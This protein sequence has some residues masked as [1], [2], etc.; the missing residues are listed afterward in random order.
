VLGA[1]AEPCIALQEDTGSVLGAEAEPCIALQED[2]GSVL[3]AEVEPCI[4]LQED[5]GSVLDNAQ[6]HIRHK[7]S[8]RTDKTLK[9]IREVGQGIQRIKMS[10]LEFITQFLKCVEKLRILL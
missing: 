9:C 5:T 10:H 2:T 8:V 4:A 6:G 1:E 7:R 3:G